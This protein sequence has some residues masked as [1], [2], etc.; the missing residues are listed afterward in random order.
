MVVFSANVWKHF[1]MP[2]ISTSF[3]R[4]LLILPLQLLI[5]DTAHSQLP[6]LSDPHTNWLGERIFQNECNLRFECLTSWN[7][8]ED[9]PSLGIGHFIWYRAGQEEA[10]TETFPELLQH[11][12]AA[13]VHLPG[14]IEALPNADS[15]WQSRQQF[16]DQMNSAKMQSLRQFLADTT[17][18]QVDFIIKRFA[19][20]VPELLS[21][22][23]ASQR[24]TIEA[25]LYHI[26]Q[27]HPPY[28]IYA[29]IDYVHFKGTGV[30]KNEHY[31][32][33]AWGLLQVLQQMQGSAVTL[34]NF[35][36]SAGIVLARRVA[37]APPER[38]EQRWLAGWKN[39]LL[40]YLPPAVEQ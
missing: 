4:Y 6:V 39:R 40:T 36:D 17:D 7:Q 19:Q 13:D 10:F 9:F 11:Y 23:R 32:G 2:A 26:G 18:L 5:F 15:P 22:V 28:G 14:W 27:S 30:D 21:E 1:K 24:Q 8:A 20:A 34:E 3:N 33:Q 35:V 37:N 25:S 16:H 29:L 31:Q 12:R 38:N